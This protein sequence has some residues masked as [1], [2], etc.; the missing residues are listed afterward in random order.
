MF[1]IA[2]RKRYN[3]GFFGWF[4]KRHDPLQYVLNVIALIIIIYGAWFNELSWICLGFVPI[5]IGYWWEYVNKK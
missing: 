2:K 3:E 1:N 4:F 5:L